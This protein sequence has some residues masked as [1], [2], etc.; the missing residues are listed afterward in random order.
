LTRLTPKANELVQAGREAL[1]PSEADRA[2][3]FQALLPRLGVGAAAGVAGLSTPSTAPAAPAAGSGLA[4]KVAAV[5]VAIGIAG[6]GLFLALN[7]EVA[8]AKPAA[9]APVPSAAQPKAPIDHAPESAPSAVPHA[10]APE[11]RAPAASS[12]PA[13]SLAEE[14]AILSQASAEL[15][16]GRPAA[17]L[18]KLEEHRRKFPRG[19]LGQERTSARI[20]ALCALG[21]TKEA[22]AELARLA[23]ASPNSPH[24]A[25]ARKACGSGL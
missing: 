17:A 2:R 21:R 6:G 11:K 14:V 25:R 24:V 10:E 12:R 5:V 4:V 16:A 19:A 13:D 1:R 3:V 8:P 9:P 7:S 23:R 18:K 15:H 20:Q 22:Q